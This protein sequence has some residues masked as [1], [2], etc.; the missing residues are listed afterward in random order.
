MQEVSCDP[1]CGPLV[2]LG[3]GELRGPADGEEEVEPALRGADFG[4]VNMEVADRIGLE[5]ALDALAVFDVREP[6][7]A[8]PL[9]S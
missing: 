2:E 4:D 3:G 1:S 8:V 9:Q 5:F 7:G 6:R